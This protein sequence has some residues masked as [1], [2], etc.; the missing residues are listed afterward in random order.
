[1]DKVCKICKTTKLK[2]EFYQYFSKRDGKHY[3]R[4][5][6]KICNIKIASKWR[7]DNKGKVEAARKLWSAKNRKKLKMNEIRICIQLNNIISIKY[8]S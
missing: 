5:E 2:S 1:M 8:L 7:N 6:C 3:F 4:P